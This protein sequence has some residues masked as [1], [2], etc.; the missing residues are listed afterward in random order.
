MA[1]GA[2]TVA[3]GA[4]CA[5][6]SFCLYS[7]PNFDGEKVEYTRQQLFCQGSEPAL[8]LRSVLP[9]GARSVVN[10]TRSAETGTGVKIYSAAGHLV[11]ATVNPGSEVQDLGGD[12]AGK[13]QTLCSYPRG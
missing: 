3:A 1:G 8:D 6:G 11:L 7:G 13:M 9:D 10:N 12:V 4:Y 5:H 2:I